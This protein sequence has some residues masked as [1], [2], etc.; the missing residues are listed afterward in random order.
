MAYKNF[1]SGG[2]EAEKDDKFKSGKPPHFGTCTIPRRVLLLFT[3][4]LNSSRSSQFRFTHG[5]MA[6]CRL[7]HLS[8]VHFLTHCNEAPALGPKAPVG[9]ITLAWAS[10]KYMQSRTISERSHGILVWRP[11]FHFPCQLATPMQAK[12]GFFRVKMH[13]P[14]D[15]RNASVILAPRYS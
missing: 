3:Y 6:F 4:Q 9:R 12:K 15:R 10:S 7:E 14:Y 8:L 11:G 13:V 5:R 1:I 2:R